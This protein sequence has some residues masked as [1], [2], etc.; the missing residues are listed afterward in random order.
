MPRVDL[1][2][3]ASL[4]TIVTATAAAAGNESRSAAYPVAGGLIEVV[5]AFSENA[6]YWCGVGDHALTRLGLPGSQRIYVWQGPSPSRARPGERAVTFGFAPPP[7]GSAP[8]LTNDV[9]IIG[10]TL[11]V[12]QA[13]KTCDERTASG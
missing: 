3:I 2:H 5:A 10:N 1:C 12:S 9:G 7:Q 11:T 8:A 6:I 4:A 13:K